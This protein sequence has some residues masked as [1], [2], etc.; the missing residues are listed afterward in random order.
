MANT[1]F[2]AMSGVRPVNWGLLI[3]DFI[4]KSLPHIGRKPSFLPPYILHLYQHYDCFTVEEEDP[5]TIVED[6]IVYKLG[7]EAEAAETGTEDSNHP[8]V[9]E[10][11]PVSL[12]EVSGSPL[13]RCHLLPDQKLDPVGKH[14]GETWTFLPGTLW[15]PPSSTSTTSWRSS[16]CNITGWSTSLGSKPS[17]GQLRTRKL[18]RELAKRADRKEIEKLE[19]EKAQLAAQVATMTKELSQKSEEI[20]KYHA[21]H[22]VVFSRIR[23]LV[24][25]PGEVVNK[26]YLYDRMMESSDPSSARQTL[27]IL[28]KYSRMMKDLLA[29]IQKVVPPSGTPKRVLYSGPPGSPTGTLYEVVGEVALLPTTLA[30]AGPSQSGGT[31]QPTSSGRAPERERS[32][33]PERIRSSEVRMKSTGLVRS[34]RGHSPTPGRTSDRSRTLDRAR[35]PVRRRMPE[36][37]TTPDCGKAP[38]A[39]ASPASVPDCRIFGAVRSPT[40]EGGVN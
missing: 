2:G 6:E 24:G 16:K 39:Q 22:V 3:H 31:S 10:E 13:P 27:P 8:A 20:Q 38:M 14:T 23:E 40:L 19:T 9:P 17:F 5:L 28:V 21:E 32:S 12:Y 18:L 4:E 33:A 1:L 30:G 36:R 35:T 37:E 11:P 26:A 29:E 34:G 15:K 7:P 25:H